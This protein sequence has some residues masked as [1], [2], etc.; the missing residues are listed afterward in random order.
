MTAVGSSRSD[1]RH[2]P[3]RL[4]LSGEPPLA[5]ANRIAARFALPAPIEVHDFPEKGNINRHT[6]A[7]D[8]FG[9]GRRQ[10]LLQ[11]INQQVF[12]R[13]RA[14]MAAMVACIEAQRANLERG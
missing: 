7:V 10:Y 5:L 13:P 11:Q 14:V 6:F 4:R 1:V 12:T 8:A 9:D 3:D 2:P